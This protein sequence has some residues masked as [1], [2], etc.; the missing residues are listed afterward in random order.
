MK[1]LNIGKAKGTYIVALAGII[2][3]GYS[4]S[5]GL[6]SPVEAQGIIISAFGLMGVR[7]AMK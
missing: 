5:Q 6:L 7:R 2:W 1:I 4:W 3:S